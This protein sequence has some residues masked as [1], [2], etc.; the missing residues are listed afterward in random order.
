MN[1]VLICVGGIPGR[2]AGEQARQTP[3]RARTLNS[4][5]CVLPLVGHAVL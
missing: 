2:Q 3:P 1:E 5:S 4:Y